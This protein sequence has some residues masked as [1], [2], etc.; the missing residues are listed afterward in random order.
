MA[1]SSSNL[2]IATDIVKETPVPEQAQL[3]PQLNLRELEIL[4][5]LVKKSTFLGE[6]IE[7]LYNMV[8]KLQTQYLD[9]TK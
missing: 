9:Q 8:I 5:S 6:D 7:P 4:L 2:K 3:T 1:F